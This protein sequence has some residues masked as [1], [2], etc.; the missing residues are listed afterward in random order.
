LSINLLFYI[1]FEEDEKE[2]E[3]LWSGDEGL[4]FVDCESEAHVW[5]ET[6]LAM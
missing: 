1:F 2:L 6:L 3:K 5:R 4:L